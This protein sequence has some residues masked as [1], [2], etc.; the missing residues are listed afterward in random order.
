MNVPVSDP[1]Q[2]KT[3]TYFIGYSRHWEVTKHMLETWLT[4]ATTS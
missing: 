2:D 3:G 4:K 1:A